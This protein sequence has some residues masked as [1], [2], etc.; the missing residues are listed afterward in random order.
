MTCVCVKES[1]NYWMSKKA[2][3]HK[4]LDKVGSACMPCIWSAIACF[5]GIAEPLKECCNSWFVFTM[6]WLPLQ[7]HAVVKCFVQLCCVVAKPVF[8]SVDSG[9]GT[10]VNIVLLCYFHP[11]YATCDVLQ[12]SVVTLIT[13]RLLC[14]PLFSLALH[15]LSN[16][17]ILVY[18]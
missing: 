1:I 14:L 2:V 16:T 3:T 18:F 10:W 5:M 12:S 15:C 6:I 13:I 7:V 11:L 8:G 17:E 4:K 9:Q